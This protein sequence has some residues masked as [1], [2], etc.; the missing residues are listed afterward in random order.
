MV[1]RSILKPE[2]YKSFKYYP[3]IRETTGGKKWQK[4]QNL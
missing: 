1:G 4:T 2:S 3:D